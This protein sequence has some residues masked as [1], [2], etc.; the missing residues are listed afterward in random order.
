MVA[1]LLTPE[2]IPNTALIILLDWTTP[3]KWLR[4]LW[5]WVQ[6]LEEVMGHTTN[7][8][9]TE[10]EEVMTSWQERGRGGSALNL[11]GTPSATA[12]DHD[13]SLPVGLGE[14]TEKLGLPL[15]VVC[16]NVRETQS[17]F[18]FCLSSLALPRLL[19][20]LFCLG[21]KDGVF[22]EKQGLERA[23]F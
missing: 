14:W 22:G 21:P 2:T 23:R 18:D 16:Q 7:E 13:G 9:R 6:V 12:A 10:M 19:T 17:L 4:E 5:T 1:P 11:D 15:C 20:T 3:H 8:A